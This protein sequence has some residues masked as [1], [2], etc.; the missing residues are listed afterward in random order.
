MFPLNLYARARHYPL[1][2]VRDRGGSVRPGIPCALFV[3]GEMNFNGSGRTCR[4]DEELRLMHLYTYYDRHPEV[5][6]AWRASKGDGH[7]RGRTSFE[8][9]CARTSG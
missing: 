9:R 7:R 8:A 2:C 6:A 1:S 3:V 5:R 4:E